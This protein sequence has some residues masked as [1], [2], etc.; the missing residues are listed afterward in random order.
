MHKQLK[1]NNKSE[2]HF[3]VLMSQPEQTYLRDIEN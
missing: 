2:R 3:R 1:L